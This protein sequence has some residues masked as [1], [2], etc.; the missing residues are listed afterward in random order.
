MI[1]IEHVLYLFLVDKNN[2]FEEI[3]EFENENETFDDVLLWFL[4]KYT[5][6]CLSLEDKAISHL[7]LEE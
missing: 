2:K 5:K 4:Y 1:N 6:Y 3:Y 7:K